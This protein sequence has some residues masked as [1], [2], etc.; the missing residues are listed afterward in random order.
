MYNLVYIGKSGDKKI[1]SNEEFHRFQKRFSEISKYF[2]DP[3]N[4]EEKRFIFEHKE[5]WQKAAL[6]ILKKIWKMPGAEIFH[7]PVDAQELQ[8]YDYFDIIKHP[9]DFSTIKIRI[10]TGFYKVA[11]DFQDDF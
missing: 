11:K 8:L 7:K 4:L 6:K 10:N 9:M 1:L 5:K 2:Q 3:Q